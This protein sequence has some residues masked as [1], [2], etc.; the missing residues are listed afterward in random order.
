ML[1]YKAPTSDVIDYHNMSNGFL[2]H[3]NEKDEQIVHS[4][5]KCLNEIL[6]YFDYHF[7]MD[8]TDLVREGLELGPE[9]TKKH[10]GWM[11][12]TKDSY[13]RSKDSTEKAGVKIR[14]ETQGIFDK[15][16][17]GTKSTFEKIGS[18]F[19]GGGTSTEKEYVTH[20]RDT[21]IEPT[22]VQ[23]GPTSGVVHQ[24]KPFA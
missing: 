17:E 9:A 13:E 21:T 1:K 12:V 19:K 24:D 22:G 14:E 5:T 16:G 7:Q 2:I 18:V 20:S 11:T 3:G 4:I 15:I 23:P 6:A 8:P 10:K